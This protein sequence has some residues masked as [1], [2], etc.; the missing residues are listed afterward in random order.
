MPVWSLL[1][2]GEM[3]QIAGTLD[4]VESLLIKQGW[5]V[6]EIKEKTLRNLIAIVKRSS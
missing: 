4:A 1:N 2:G 3:V 6:N 5:R